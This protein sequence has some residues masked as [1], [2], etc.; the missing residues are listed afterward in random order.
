[1]NQNC[2]FNNINHEAIVFVPV[3]NKLVKRAQS[4]VK[5]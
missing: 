2:T 1:M 3:I 4:E 5:Q